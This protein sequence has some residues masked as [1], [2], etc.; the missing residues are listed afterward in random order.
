[1]DIMMKAAQMDI[2]NE[3]NIVKRWKTMVAKAV[4]Q[5][6]MILIE[7][8]LTTTYPDFLGGSTICGACVWICPLQLQLVHTFLISEF[9]LQRRC[10]KTVVVAADKT[11]TRFKETLS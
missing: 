10:N 5:E 1:M 11:N 3:R 8:C 6:E 9:V 2:M 7:W 4:F